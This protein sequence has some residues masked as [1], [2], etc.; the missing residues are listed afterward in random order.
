MDKLLS[1]AA[2]ELGSRGGK[3][4][5]KKLGEKHYL[6]MQRLSVKK[7]KANK[8]AVDK[9]KNKNLELS[10]SQITA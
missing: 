2:K 9:L 4:T 8:L 6:E 7:R 1:I 3:A 10:T 5:K